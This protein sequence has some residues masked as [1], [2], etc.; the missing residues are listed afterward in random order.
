MSQSELNA[1]RSENR[2]LSRQLE[3][4]QADLA[5]KRADESAPGFLISHSIIDTAPFAFFQFNKD[6]VVQD[7][8][9]AFARLIGSSKDK[10]IGVNMLLDLND[11]VLKREIRSCLKNGKGLFQGNYQSITADKV[12]PTKM[13]FRATYNEQG[14]V[15]GGIGY[16]E[17]LTGNVEAERALEESKHSYRDLF[18]NFQ[19]AIYILD[20]Q[21]CFLAVNK[22]AEQMYGY[23]SSF[24]IGKTPDFISA[25]GRNNMEDV[26]EK[27]NLAL[28]GNAQSFVF[29]GLKSNGVEFPKEVRVCRGI[30]QGQAVIIA[31]ASDITELKRAQMQKEL[32]Y[33]ISRATQT[34]TNAQ[35][36][37]E[38]INE[39][40]SKHINTKNLFIGILNNERDR[41][42]IPYMADQKDELD[43]APLKGTICSVVIS[44]KKSI[45]LN[46]MEIKK[47]EDF[48]IIGYVG[49]SCKSWLGVPL[50]V[51]QEVIGILVVRSYERENA[52][53]SEDVHLLEFVTNHIAISIKHFSIKEHIRNLTEAIEQSPVSLSISDDNG[54]V[55]YANQAHIRSTGMQLD[56]ILGKPCPLLTESHKVDG[57]EVVIADYLKDHNQWTGEILLKRKDGTEYWNSLVVSTV[58]SE[59]GRISYLVIGDD[60][61]EEKKI[62]RQLNQAKKMESVGTLAGGIAHDFNNLLT[63]VNGYAELLRDSLHD[64][65]ELQNKANNIL[66]SGIR[67]KEMTSKLLA[68]SRQQIFSPKAIEFNRFISAQKGIFQRLI[69]EDIQIHVHLED[70]LPPVNADPGQ[71]EQVL[72]NLIVNSRDAIQERTENTDRRI[73]IAAKVCWLDEEFVSNHSG[74]TEGKHI[75]I[76]VKDT[77]VGISVD[78][79]EK[80]FDPFYTTKA[81]G[82]G[83][84]LGLS[85]VYG[86]VKQNK[87]SV[88]IKSEPGRGTEVAIYWPV[89]DEEKGEGEYKEVAVKDANLQGDE[90]ILLV[91]DDDDVRELSLTLLSRQGYKVTCAS[92]GEQALKEV[93]FAQQAKNAPDILV[94]DM[95]MPGMTGKE[96]A[97][98]LTEKIPD[99][100]VLFTSGY[101]DSQIV[102]KG[103][104]LEGLHFLQKP[105]TLPELGQKVRDILDDLPSGSSLH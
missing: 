5:Q 60:V 26:K 28:D 7:C 42:L 74:S 52:F 47:M 76:T 78:V 37:Y 23:P 39:Q 88:Y 45:L 21:G 105:F 2:R 69:G 32:V 57:E 22:R 100:K 33:N 91:E 43:E 90:H 85:T 82:K 67:A 99:L 10:L 72:L 6:G 101:A 94:T 62:M 75:E 79:M 19:D 55:E 3:Q 29:W 34:M 71:I 89:S 44:E 18:D 48:S 61:T 58:V 96:L 66:R 98:I 84:G 13:T 15:I 53:T 14:E 24:F 20:E 27:L 86:I 54:C 38:Y 25:P 40:L 9:Q 103:A 41:L 56:E 68:F 64:Q 70:D 12:T 87:G 1:L 63:V 36:L 73:D 35:D 46:E 30:H 49:S 4:I 97:T 65:P 102:D 92:S 59:Q 83:T 80:I 51:D 81:Q 11:E 104:I 77:G 8:N 31:F 95:V 16:G 17:D 93:E 50:L